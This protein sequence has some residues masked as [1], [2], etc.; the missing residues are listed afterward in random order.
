[1][2][3]KQ[4]LLLVL[5][6]ISISSFGIK[7]DS[8]YVVSPKDYGL[9]VETEFI[10]TSDKVKLASW[11]LPSSIKE[12]KN[13][14]IIISY[15][16]AGNMSYWLHIAVGLVNQGFDVMLY[17][18]RGFGKSDSFKVNPKIL[19][20]PEYITDLNTVV[21]YAKGVKP[22]NSIC[23]MGFSM[24][25]VISMLYLN[26][27]GYE[28]ISS[29]IGEGH[30][31]SPNKAKEI[32]LSINKEVVLFPDNV[33]W[34]S[35]YSKMNIPVLLFCGKDDIY[36]SKEVME[37]MVNEIKGLR[38]KKFDGGHLHGYSILQDN[39][40]KEISDFVDAVKE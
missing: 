36:C 12:S 6:L 5:L 31:Y 29:Y 37:S 21:D 11:F 26:N 32:L 17:D 3:L 33:D 25:S 22:N 1:M 7:P 35:F 20:Y 27:Y 34:S 23:L 13:T 8:I 9:S 4:I 16:D 38:I 15:G 40:F 19:Y 24:G 39:Y 18:Y 30:V 2:K 14:S 10:T 28:N